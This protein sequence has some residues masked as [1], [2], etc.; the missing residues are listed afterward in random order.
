ML[1][2]NLPGQDEEDLLPA[3]RLSLSGLQPG[4]DEGGRMALTGKES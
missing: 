3:A 1:V 4:R 2:H